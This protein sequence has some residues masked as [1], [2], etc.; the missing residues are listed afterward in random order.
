MA[1]RYDLL[2]LFLSLSLSFSGEDAPVYVVLQPIHFPRLL[3]AV[4]AEKKDA[5]PPV[6]LNLSQ[7][8]PLVH[9]LVT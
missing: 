5:L 3:A 7:T 9:N 1:T 2:V 6:I 4:I 8:I